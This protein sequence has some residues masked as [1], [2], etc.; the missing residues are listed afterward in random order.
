MGTTA[1]D[2][3]NKPYEGVYQVPI[4]ME[5]TAVMSMGIGSNLMQ[6]PDA[7]SD[8]GIPLTSDSDLLSLKGESVKHPENRRIK[9][10]Y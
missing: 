6:R 5:F 2:G 9:C 4:V 1:S 8:H 7:M 10:S 3:Q